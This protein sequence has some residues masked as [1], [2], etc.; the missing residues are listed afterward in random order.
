MV[1]VGSYLL[2]EETL[3][4]QML[5]LDLSNDNEV[6]GEAI[7]STNDVR[8]RSEASLT[9][10][11]IRSKQ[12]IQYGDSIFVG[13]NSELTF[14]VYPIEGDLHLG[15]GTLLQVVLDQGAPVLDFQMGSAE[16]DL[17][18]GQSVTLTSQG[19][20]SVLDGTGDGGR[21]SL[22]TGE[23]GDLVIESLG[24]Q[25]DVQNE[26]GQRSSVSE[27]QQLQVS[28]QGAD[29]DRLG[30]RLLKSPDRETWLWPQDPLR[31]EWGQEI[32][33][34][35][36]QISTQPDFSQVITSFA[37]RGTSAEL[38]SWQQEGYFYWRLQSRELS[39]APPNLFTLNLIKP[40]LL[41]FPIADF[42]FA[43]SELESG[44]ALEVEF[45][46]R[47][48]PS[49][50]RHILEISQSPDF[51]SPLVQ[52]QVEGRRHRLTFFDNGVYHWRVRTDHGQPVD[53]LWSQVGRF[54]VGERDLS[55]LTLGSET[56]LESELVEELLEV[57]EALEV[58]P[59][60]LPSAPRLS[61]SLSEVAMD[62]GGRGLVRF[63]WQE[64]PGA[65]GYE[66]Q[67]ARSADFTQDP[68]QA[69]TRSTSML[70][71]SQKPGPVFWRVR[72]INENGEWGEYSL[73]SSLML[74]APGPQVPEVVEARV[75]VERV[76]E[77]LNPEESHSV[78][79]RF[80]PLDGAHS[81]KVQWASTPDFSGAK[82]LTTT[83]SEVKLDLEQTGKYYARVIAMVD[84]EQALS[85]HSRPVEI[86]YER[87]LALQPPRLI[88]PLNNIE[89]VAFAAKGQESGSSPSY[90]FAWR[91][92]PEA[93]KYVVQFSQTSDFSNLLMEKESNNRQLVL[94]ETLPPGRIFWRVRA[95]REKFFSPWSEIWSLQTRGG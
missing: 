40:P 2:S 74:L 72:A 87:A 88:Q 31:F 77:L 27:G 10:L 12:E 78:N 41:E 91:A 24:G 43:R 46:F 36:I 81:Y 68:Q 75:E 1:A 16:L 3:L 38:P 60:P 54:W 82:S 84:E 7:S 37:A 95:E 63:A 15:P 29:Q 21:V 48:R 58:E 32:E 30:E 93:E 92:V 56:I 14:R 69:T 71:Q 55:L 86:R 34:G 13:S 39:Q 47:S 59:P 18:P 25:I 9:W 66:V 45:R 61:T 53:E 94:Q 80:Q 35:R 26:A 83:Q 62:E 52:D 70:W 50:S 76:T 44:Q 51:A 8:R 89:V 23:G 28:R 57:V 19:R 5:N 79:L 73:A 6:V 65:R 90:F 49:V 20:Q 17:A 42:L 11:P 22:R 33:R 67:V 85:T 4:R 64:V